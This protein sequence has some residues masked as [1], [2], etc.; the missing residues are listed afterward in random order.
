MTD[1]VVSPA[2]K[3]NP[4]INFLTG[5]WNKIESV[6]SSINSFINKITN[7]QPVLI[8]AIAAVIYYFVRPF[9]SVIV[10]IP[11]ELIKVSLSALAVVVP[12]IINAIPYIL[13]VCVGL[14]V[15]VEI[16]N[17]VKSLFIKK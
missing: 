16:V 6:D 13:E 11:A 7:Q 9:V 14:L 3:V 4:I 15:L 10:A 12:F 1:P 5:L 2:P 8:V 17:F